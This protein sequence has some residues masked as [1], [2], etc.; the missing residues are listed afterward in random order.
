MA[1]IVAS[2]TSTAAVQTAVN[3]AVDGDQVHI[4]NG[5]ASWT[6]GISTTKQII[7]RAQNYTPT[8]A[9][10]SGAGATS[11]NLTITNNSSASLFEFTS[12]NAFHCGVGGIRFN[13]G[14]GNGS[15]I[16]LGGGGTKVPLIFDCYFQNKSRNSPA[17]RVIAQRGRGGVM[18]NCVMEGTF[19]TD[20]VG[21]G[22]LLILN[23]SAVAG[24][25]TWESPSSLGALDITGTIN[26]YMEDTTIKNCGNCPDIDTHGRFVARHFIYDGAWGE[27][28]G[29]TSSGYGGRQFEFYDGVFKVTTDFRNMSRR[30]FW[31]RQ[32]HGIFADLEV[33]ETLDTSDFGSMTLLNIG[34]TTS[35]GAYL[36]ARQPGCGHNGTSYVSDPIYLQNHTGAR[37]YTWSLNGSWGTVVQ[38]NRDIFVNNGNKPGY[39][40]F[41]YPH[42]LRTV[43]EGGGDTTPPAAPTGVTVT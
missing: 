18:W 27:T 43:V 12:G 2:G 39:S 31:C 7:I 24:V 1:I 41:T 21:E 10:T 38:Q 11:R 37:A 9:G 36:Y 22:S 34:D 17:G 3:T 35:P 16:A 20:Q 33:Q 29:Y 26:F 42:P 8:P 13:E 32:G 6:S 15:M 4:P 23:D 30:Y 5:S 14:T 28:H 40:K 25:N 19:P